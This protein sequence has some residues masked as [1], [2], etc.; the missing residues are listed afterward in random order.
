MV[1]RGVGGTLQISKNL[2]HSSLPHP[3]IQHESDI[4]RTEPILLNLSELFISPQP[5]PYFSYFYS[6]SYVGDG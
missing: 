6:P 5:S 3:S 2:T 4:V 1:G